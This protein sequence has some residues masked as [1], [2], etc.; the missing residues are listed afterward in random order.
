MNNANKVSA[1]I[2]DWAG[3]IVDFGSLQPALAFRDLFLVFGIDVTLD[4]IRKYMGM[5]KRS[6]LAEMLGND[7]INNSW[8]YKYNRKPNNNDVEHLLFEYEKIL[9]QRIRYKLEFIPDFLEAVV[10]LRK[11]GIKIGT[12]TGYT[13]PIVAEILKSSERKGFVPDAVVCASDVPQGRPYPWMCFK[14]AIELECY[15]LNRIVN[16][17]D[18]IQDI[19]AGYNADMWT[20]GVIRTGNELGMSAEEIESTE[21]SELQYKVNKIKDKFLASG[22]DYV[23]DGV[24]DI[25]E[26]VEEINAHLAI[27]S[28]NTLCRRRSL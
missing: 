13:K 14:A 23:I 7:S 4:L 21:E 5:D 25:V 22:A 17:G 10:E 3:T 1:V 18:T 27:R 11:M 24:W 12:T 20:V 9:K 28:S 19:L 6:H 16:I 8:Q 15:P 26:V 2:F